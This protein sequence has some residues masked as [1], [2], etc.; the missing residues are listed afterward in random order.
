MGRRG[1]RATRVDPTSRPPT[2][3]RS[4]SSTICR[5][6]ARSCR[7]PRDRRDSPSFPPLWLGQPPRCEPRP[8]STPSLPGGPRDGRRGWPWRARLAEAHRRAAAG[9]DPRSRPSTRRPPAPTPRTGRATARE[10]SPAPRTRRRTLLGRRS[11]ARAII[12]TSST[13]ASAGSSSIA[14]RARRRSA[15]PADD[16]LRADGRVA[17]VRLVGLASLRE[18]GEEAAAQ[19]T[20][21]VVVAFFRISATIAG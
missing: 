6:E 15:R 8:R 12:A 4:R 2:E 5:S 10:R 1:K 19:R 13:S 11:P 16:D 18:V 7:Y 14:S 17:R 9:R 21:L 20:A 3:E